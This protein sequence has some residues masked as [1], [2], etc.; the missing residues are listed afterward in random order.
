MQPLISVVIPV[1][2]GEK[3]LEA[4][5]RSVMRQTVR[6]MEII[7]VDDGSTDGTWALLERLAAGDERIRPVHRENGGVSEARNTA[8][9]LCSGRYVRFV[10]ADD[11]LPEDAMAI[12]LERTRAA[13]SDLTIAPYVEVMGPMH[14]LRDLAR[15]NDCIGTDAFLPFVNRWSNS[16]YVGV[17]WNKL[18][19]RSIIA[20]NGLRF[21]KGVR[22]GEDFA[23]VC[24]YLR[25]AE[26]V[27]FADKPVYLY[28]RNPQG[29]T[30]GFALNCVLHPLRNSRMKGELYSHL[31]QLFVSRN[32]YAAYRRTLWLYL[33]RFTVNN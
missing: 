6:D 23:F 4:S 17:L 32:A 13:G 16:F 22:W 7:V 20:D 30:V 26:R 29:I 14:N 18:F 27:A 33:F 31:K 5:L 21:V 25:H 8:L 9:G 19:L 28:H 24:D 3:V 12:L 1:Y 10:D 11:E 15:R 2:N